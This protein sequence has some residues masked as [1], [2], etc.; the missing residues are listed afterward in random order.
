MSKAF[1]LGDKVLVLASAGSCNKTG[2]I[3]IITEIDGVHHRVTV[4]GRPNRS[5]FITGEYLELVKEIILPKEEFVL[6][7]D[8]EDVVNLVL[9][10]LRSLGVPINSQLKHF[11]S[12]Y[13]FIYWNGNTIVLRKNASYYI[14]AIHDAMEFI[15]LFTDPKPTSKTIPLNEKKD[16]D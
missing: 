1:R 7:I 15:E 6:S 16:Y 4:P 9:L 2:D 12:D 5:N 10:H 11:D 8:N 13:P 3:G 14:A